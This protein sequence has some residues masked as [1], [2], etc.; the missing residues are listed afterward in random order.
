MFMSTAA[1]VTIVKMEEK[2]NLSIQDEFI[3]KVKHINVVVNYK[4]RAHKRCNT[5]EL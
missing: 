2:K 1:L 5:D 3:I 4:G